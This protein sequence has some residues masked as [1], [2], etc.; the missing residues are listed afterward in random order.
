M[1]KILL[2]L[3]I[4]LSIISHDALAGVEVTIH[5]PT[6]KMYV[7]VDGQPTYE[8]RVSTA[9]RGYR[10]PAGVYK[11]YWL[12]KNHYSSIYDNAPM[13]YSVFFFGN[14]AVHGT[15][16]V[17]NLG[18]RASHGCVR[19]LIENARTLFMLVQQYGKQNVRIVIEPA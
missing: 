13:P 8:W 6:Q 18:R 15:T 10:T 2:G 12:H 1:R 19:L 3:C 4:A 7:S 11:P 16:E 14:Y 5:K 17:K 9:V